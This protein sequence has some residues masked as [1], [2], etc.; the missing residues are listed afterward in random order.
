MAAPFL[1]WYW[2]GST[3]GFI[4]SYY[5]YFYIPMPRKMKDALMYGKAR[6]KGEPNILERLTNVPKQWFKYFYLNSVICNGFILYTIIGAYFMNQRPPSW[7]VDL[8]SGISFHPLYQPR[9][10]QISILI[11]MCLM[12]VQGMRR[13]L[14]CQFV[15][16]YSNSQMNVIHFLLGMTFYPALGPTILSEGPHILQKASFKSIPD[17]GDHIEPYHV[18][19]VVLFLWGSWHQNRA[20]VIF[21]NLRKTDADKNVH[22]I[23]YGDWFEYVSNPHYLSEIIIYTGV[24]VV[25]GF[26]HTLWWW[27]MAFVVSN[28]VAMGEVFHK[29]YKEKFDNYPVHRKVIIPWIY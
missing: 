8:L 1:M 25:L 10:S 15:S 12:V 19:G 24:A 6:S 11:A 27:V 23:P 28:Q 9:V 16:K 13:F 21:A 22:K 17:L 3:F 29:W 2:C 26:K 4:A 18:F 5:L 20:C 14:E 7:F